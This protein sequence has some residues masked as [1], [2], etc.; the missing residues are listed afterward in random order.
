MCTLVSD[1]EE[2]ED[3][4][5]CVEEEDVDCPFCFP[6]FLEAVDVLEEELDLTSLLLVKR[7]LL[8]PTALGPPCL[9]AAALAAA[10]ISAALKV[11][12]VFSGMKLEAGEAAAAAEAPLGTG[13]VSRLLSSEFV[14][15]GSAAVATLVVPSAFLTISNLPSGCLLEAPCL[16]RLIFILR[17]LS[18][19]LS[20]ALVLP[21]AL[22][23][24]VSVRV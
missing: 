24:R 18:F 4:E 1:V 15:M 19:S 10:T 7:T 2:L 13:E 23:L 21:M 5:D 17:L 12:V 16:L 11:P 8:P 6:S 20:L 14:S 22:E 3:D 9:T